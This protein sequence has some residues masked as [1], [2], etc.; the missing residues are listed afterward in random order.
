[1]YR[2]S[3]FLICLFISAGLSAD[4]GLVRL[5][6]NYS[7]SE[8]LDR[9]E[10]AVRAKGMTVFARV[11][12]SAG[13]AGV[14]LKLAPNAVLIFGNPKIGTLL[15]QSQAT[16]GI[17]LPMKALAFMDSSGQV[18]LVYNAPQ[19]LADRHQIADRSKVIAKMN[20]ALGAFA[21]KATR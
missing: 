4:E 18:W 12:H 11:D 8:T 3:V 17:D 19:Y 15:M 2:L 14:D 13:A 21:E 9:F 7:V 20:K 1:M 16:A 10:A 6:S 5:K